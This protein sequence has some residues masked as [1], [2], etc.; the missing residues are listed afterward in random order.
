MIHQ[1]DCL[2]DISK[3][4]E[5]PTA[6]MHTHTHTHTHTPLDLAAM[7]MEARTHR[8]RAGL[9]S[10]QVPSAGPGTTLLSSIRGAP[11][12]VEVGYESHWGKGL[13]TADT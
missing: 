11:I 10:E 8:S 13:L 7:N 9:E 12:K 6:P 1:V 5:S 4:N 3:D 2:W